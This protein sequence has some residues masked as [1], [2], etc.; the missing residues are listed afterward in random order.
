MLAALEE[1]INH[2]S[3]ILRG[4]PGKLL[5]GGFSSAKSVPQLERTGVQLVVNCARGMELFPWYEQYLEKMADAKICIMRLDW[6]DCLHQKL[7]SNVLDNVCRAI[8]DTIS[9]KGSVLV[10]C[11][12]G[13]SRSAAATTAYL[14]HRLGMTAD[15]AIS[16]LQRKRLCARPNSNFTAQLREY[17]PKA[18]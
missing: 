14:M 11:A 4:L 9:R 1:C 8:D 12:A 15:A 3:V 16:F 17:T 10:H 18:H 5:L 6:D 2:P 13:R 7:D